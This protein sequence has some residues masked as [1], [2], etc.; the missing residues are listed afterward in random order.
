[1]NMSVNRLSAL[2]NT[3]STTVTTQDIAQEIF[4]HCSKGCNT[5]TEDR[6]VN[7]A[8]MAIEGLCQ[9][10]KHERTERQA[11]VRVRTLRQTPNILPM[12]H[13]A[14][15]TPSLSK[16]PCNSLLDGWGYSNQLA[17]PPLTSY[18]IMSREPTKS[19]HNSPY[20]DIIQMQWTQRS[21][22][23]K[24]SDLQRSVQNKY[25]LIVLRPHLGK[26]VP[27]PGRNY[28]VH[29]LLTID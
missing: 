17:S 29:L 20:K 14:C 15:R 4:W 16:T 12:P 2:L 24:I 27:W 11:T 25:N 21:N 26:P 6:K 23:L 7:T 9:A 13:T 8:P 10:F 28:P 18:T 3:D 22:P 19:C 1:M 5:L